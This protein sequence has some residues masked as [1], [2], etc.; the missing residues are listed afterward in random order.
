MASADAIWRTFLQPLSVRDDDNALMHDIAI[1][2]EANKD[3]NAYAASEPLFD[4]L[5]AVADQLAQK[6]VTDHRLQQTRSKD[7]S[8]Q[9]KQ[10]ENGLLLNKYFLLYEKLLY[11]LNSGDIGR[12][13]TCIVAWI[14]IF[15]AMGKHKYATQMT[16]FLYNNHFTYPEG[17]RK[18]IWY[19]ILVN[20]MGKKG[21]FRAIDWYVELNNLF[22][23]VINGGKIS[24]HTAD[25]IILELPLWNML[26]SNV[27][28]QHTEVDISQT[29]KQLCKY[30]MAHSLHE[31]KLG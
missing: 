23:K 13:E 11:T 26:H 14:L 4:D 6:Y 24:N 16:N 8:Q 21:N 29:F 2:V 3:L 18:V 10:Y 20:P 19:N 5:K 31:L 7:H 15:K 30:I 28:N 27:T 9:D 12:M 17:L 25:H 1:L 22:I